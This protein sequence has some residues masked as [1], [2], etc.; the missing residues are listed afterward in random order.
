[1]CKENLFVNLFP[2]LDYNTRIHLNIAL[3]NNKRVHRKLNPN[4]IKQV[5]LLFNFTKLKKGINDME[6]LRGEPRLDAF[7][8]YFQ[9]ILPR[10]LLICQ[11]DMKFREAVIKKLQHYND[12]YCPEYI[13]SDDSL[14]DSVM[15]LCKGL[16]YNI[17]T[18]HPYLYTLKLPTTDE[19]WSPI[20]YSPEVTIEEK[21]LLR[22]IKK[23]KF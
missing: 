11:H 10:N 9:I 17:L 15:P 22:V 13:N 3:P 5:E 18:K 7:L 23:K 12:H 1:M 16:L 20:D 6:S 4:V 14:M 8:N 21:K 2:Y 19:N